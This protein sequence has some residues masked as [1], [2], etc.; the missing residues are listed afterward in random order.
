LDTIDARDLISMLC[1]GNLIAAAN[2][3]TGY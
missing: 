1:H 2:R 3:L